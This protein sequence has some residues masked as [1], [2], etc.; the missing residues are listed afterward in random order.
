MNTHRIPLAAY[1]IPLFLLSCNNPAPT[2]VIQ[3]SSTKTEETNPFILGS[4]KIV[5]LENED[6]ELFLK[7]YPWK[8][9]QTNTGLRYEITSEGK[10]KNIEAGESVT[11]KY[12]TFLLTGEEIYN[13]DDAGAK[14]FVVDKSEEIA[15]LHE[16]V[17]L[18]KK[19]AE[20]RLII[21]SHLAYGVAGDGNKIKPYQ[22]IIMKIKIV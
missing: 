10:G 19:G 7:R 11:L 15:G 9:K 6:I 8:M 17:K 18:T 14:Q 5:E 22:T 13:S 16:A 21:P 4:Q 12:R 20:A 2:G 1:L 3:N